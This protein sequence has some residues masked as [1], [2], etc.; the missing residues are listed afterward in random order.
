MP[1]LAVK[2]QERILAE[3]EGYPVSASYSL[4]KAA[5]KWLSKFKTF[6]RTTH[7]TREAA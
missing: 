3:H 1:R 6:K 7:D 4:A 2:L 5:Q